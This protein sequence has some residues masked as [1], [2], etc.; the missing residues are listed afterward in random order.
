MSKYHVFCGLPLGSYPKV[1][2]SPVKFTSESIPVIAGALP[3]GPLL[4]P[5]LACTRGPTCPNCGRALAGV[6]ASSSGWSCEACEKLK[7]VVAS[8]TRDTNSALKT[9]LLMDGTSPTLAESRTG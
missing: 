7:R 4:V 1:W 3:V 9:L 5:A 6:L 8:T 2:Y